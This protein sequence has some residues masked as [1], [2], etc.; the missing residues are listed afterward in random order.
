VD[1][2]GIDYFGSVTV[3]YN[4]KSACDAE[5][6]Y[7]GRTRQLELLNLFNQ[8]ISDVG[9]AHLEGST[10]VREL[11]LGKT[12]ITDAGLS[13]LKAISA[14]QQIYLDHTFVADDE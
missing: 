11:R 4:C 10:N 6:V 7:V 2:V 12:R 13:H 3:V 14:L 8:P 5:M 9:L 1:V